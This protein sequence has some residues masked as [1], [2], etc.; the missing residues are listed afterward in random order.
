V[1]A[2]NASHEHA[3]KRIAWASRALGAAATELDELGA[4]AAGE[5]IADEAERVQVLAGEVAELAKTAV[6]PASVLC[7]NLTAAGPTP[8]A[9]GSVTR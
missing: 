4:S 1:V 8:G 5:V 9:R 3:A 6:R 2:S 7:S